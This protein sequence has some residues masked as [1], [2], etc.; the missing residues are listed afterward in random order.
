MTKRPDRPR[1]AHALQFVNCSGCGLLHLQLLDAEGQ[2][3]AVALLAI[4][5]AV[6]MI[7]QMHDYLR[8]KTGAPE[9]LLL[10]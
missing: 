10:H 3:F 8:L 1:I 9:S 7:V 4:Q 6:Q 5:D 2:E